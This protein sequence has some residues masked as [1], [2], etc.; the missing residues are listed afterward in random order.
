MQSREEIRNWLTE[1]GG[2]WPAD[3][4]TKKR[5]DKN[6]LVTQETKRF[7]NNPKGKFCQIDNV[8]SSFKYLD[9]MSK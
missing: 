9:I 2:H 7:N 6:S 4:S 3:N 8:V 5:P 1:S